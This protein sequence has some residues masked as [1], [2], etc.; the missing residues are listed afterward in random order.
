LE[1]VVYGLPIAVAPGL[2]TIELEGAP[3]IGGRYDGWATDHTHF[4]SS[5][6]D[7]EVTVGSPGSAKKLITVGAYVTR[8]HWQSETGDFFSF[9]EENPIGQ[10]ASFSSYGPT[11][12]GR[13]KPDLTAPGVAIVSSLAETARPMLSKDYIT[14]DR[15]HSIARGTSFSAPHVTGAIALL[16]QQE[17]RL[18]IS[19]IKE[20]LV[21]LAKQDSF[22][23][24]TPNPVWG[25]GKLW[26]STSATPDPNPD[27][28]PKPI[29]EQLRLLV[30][31]FDQNKNN[32]LD[33][34][35]MLMALDAWIRSEY[36]YVLGREFKDEEIL[37]LLNL[38][39]HGI[40]S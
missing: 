21:K 31:Q 2:W 16:L 14:L 34:D 1:I 15:K 4:T 28:D 25:A 26:I 27:P 12:D 13:L 7:S 18:T 30:R 39:Q 33:D 11:R 19:Q 40:P 6:A 3:S 32:Q 9:P 35:E 5:N 8:D 36:V 24:P 10:I 38:W 22:T 20:R 29:S 37:D 17:P 23:G